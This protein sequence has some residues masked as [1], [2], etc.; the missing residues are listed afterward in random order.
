M[1]MSRSDRPGQAIALLRKQLERPRLPA[2]PAADLRLTLARVLIDSERPKAAV[3]EMVEVL[4]VDAH[5]PEALL[6]L[7]EAL[8]ACDELDRARDILDRARRSGAD[9]TRLDAICELLGEPP[10]THMTAPKP[11]PVPGRPLAFESRED[12]IIVAADDEL[13]FMDEE[14]QTSPLL[15][16]GEDEE[17]LP[18]AGDPRDQ[19]RIVRPEPPSWSVGDPGR[20]AN[21]RGPASGALFDDDEDTVTGS[22]N[23]ISSHVLDQVDQQLAHHPQVALGTRS[24]GLLNALPDQDHVATNPGAPPPRSTPP[25]QPRHSDLTNLPTAP[26]PV[27]RHSHMDLA[28]RSTAT[29]TDGFKP[30]QRL[31]YAARPSPDAPPQI[32]AP[33]A[34]TALA[35]PRHD[36]VPELEPPSATDVSKPATPPSP[37][38]SEAREAAPPSR[39]RH[40]DLPALDTSHGR[41]APAQRSHAALD[42]PPPGRRHHEVLQHAPQT[43]QLAL[44]SEH[45][46]VSLLRSSSIQLQLDEGDVEQ[47][48]LA[49]MIGTTLG[50]VALLTIALFFAPLAHYQRVTQELEHHT[51]IAEQKLRLDTWVSTTTAAKH[52]EQAVE[53]TGPLGAQLGGVLDQYL[54]LI[55]VSDHRAQRAEARAALAE[56]EA[57]LAT[58]YG[59]RQRLERARALVE[60]LQ[61]ERYHGPHL[62]AAMA[63]LHIEAKEY[64][65]ALVELEQATSTWPFDPNLRYLTG[66]ALLR[67]GNRTGAFAQFDR[68]HQLD[69][70]FI[71]AQL[72]LGAW[73]ARSGN[74]RALAIWDRVLEQMSPDHVGAMIARASF[75]VQEGRELNK[76]RVR[77]QRIIT[78]MAQQASPVELSQAHL[79]L[80]RYHLHYEKTDDAASEMREA[81]QI[82]PTNHD[83]R[84]ELLNLLLTQDRLDEARLLI[85]RSEERSGEDLTRQRAELLMRQSM[86]RMAAE[87]LSKRSDD[88]DPLLQ[89]LLGQALV[90]ERSFQAAR[91]AFE[92]ALKEA[93]RLA[94][95]GLSADLDMIRAIEGRDDALRRLEDRLRRSES[96]AHHWRLGQVLEARGQLASATHHFKQAARLDTPG[97]FRFNFPP[98]ADLCRVETKQLALSRAHEYCLFAL[99]QR[100]SYTTARLLLARIDLQR[101]DHH[102]ARGRL[103]SILKQDPR[104]PQARLLHARALVMLRDFQAARGE[105]EAMLA[106]HPEDGDLL[107]LQG[108]MELHMHY[109]SRALGYLERAL[110]ANPTDRSLRLDLAWTLL[111]LGKTRDARKHLKKLV[112]ESAWEGLALV[113]L[114]E[115]D[116]QQGD[117]RVGLSR[118]RDGLRLM[119][120]HHASPWRLSQ[121]YTTLARLEEV[122]NDLEHRSVGEALEK[123]T[124]QNALYA[125]AYYH[126]SRHHGARRELDAE[127]AA[128]KEAVER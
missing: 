19:P 44:P 108:L 36:A 97:R 96:A 107:A 98:S 126:K 112:R 109:P 26:I 33:R 21:M 110:K 29:H 84:L 40:T 9:P 80:G 58:R 53:T 78:H 70:R 2:G 79:V 56:V 45:T 31:H 55:G 94:R 8:I 25:T 51:P 17:T 57:T 113:A 32:P 30:G 115:A 114:A 121:G 54:T 125:P 38:V 92:R 87:M 77:L 41:Q 66:L 72:E 13:I 3:A 14:D 67:Q 120:R 95:E 22:F 100:P 23:G 91:G 127:I 123:A 11:P 42:A 59:E 74:E 47:S 52:L 61:A 68:A 24:Y 12:T 75:R 48:R 81:L 93:P 10:I 106:D 16:F 1:K 86:P 20:G 28:A 64:D 5:R 6:L 39:V 117:T 89:V 104:H 99:R 101:G 88:E 76:A 82:D 118:A 90:E 62:A 122:R 60:A 50:A 35:P 102:E 18:W 34:R 7:A 37:A 124:R 103:E 83:A 105:I 73:F 43:E 63:L 46:A 15:Y 116:R 69:S 49:W 119:E 128:L 71:P 4:R 85:E 65:A 111:L 27:S